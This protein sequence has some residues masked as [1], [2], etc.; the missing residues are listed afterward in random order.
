MVQYS[1][2]CD[3]AAVISLGADDIGDEVLGRVERNKRRTNT[4]K[5]P[6]DNQTHIMDGMKME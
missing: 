5:Q 6:T 1:S 2:L 3:G 4:K